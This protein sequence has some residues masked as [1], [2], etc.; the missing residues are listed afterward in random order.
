MYF[1]GKSIEKKRAAEAL[2]AE[3]FANAS[4]QDQKLIL[5]QKKARLLLQMR[6]R[7][8]EEIAREEQVRKQNSSSAL[9]DDGY[10]ILKM[11]PNPALGN[12]KFLCEPDLTRSMAIPIDATNQPVDWD[13]SNRLVNALGGAPSSSRDLI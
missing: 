13:S 6:E 10:R 3:E 12:L 4:R 9:T 2:E 11:R 8:D 7:L 1:V 5:S